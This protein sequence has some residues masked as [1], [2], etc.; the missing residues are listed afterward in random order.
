ML[1]VLLISLLLLYVPPVPETPSFALYWIPV[2]V[3]C[4]AGVNALACWAGS[5]TAVHLSNSGT[6][7]GALRAV[8]VFK[9]LNLGILGFV[10]LDVYALRWPL[11][12][13]EAFGR[14]PHVPLAAELLLLS[15]VLLMIGTVM[16]FQY[17][18]NR[19]QRPMSL[20]LGQYLLLRFRTELAILLVPWLLLVL[21]WDVAGALWRGSAHFGLVEGLLPIVLVGAIVA[22]AP[23]LLRLLWNTSPLPPGPVRERLEAFGR[24]Q[25]FR[26]RDIL[27]WHTHNYLPNAAVVGM[28]PLLRYVLLTDALL[29]NC[30]EEEIEGV[31][32]HEVGHIKHHHL[33]FYMLFVLAFVCFYANA[34][35]ILAGLGYVAP[36]GNVMLAELT[37]GHAIVMLVFAALYWIFGFGYLSR[38]F[39]QQADL[40]SMSSSSNPAAFVVALHKLAVL[41]GA[42]SAMRSWRHFSIS[43]RTEFLADVLE[44]PDLGR[45]AERRVR[46]VQLIIIALF[47]AAAL[48]LVLV[49]PGMVGL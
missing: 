41:S 3:L 26:C 23:L 37:H 5:R 22:F 36:L 29:A 16:A 4:L 49:A 35:D 27:L 42:P 28:I 10:V 24:A 43:R 46:L 11:L 25:G 1:P 31:F 14:P 45:R 38:R 19:T 20:R 32:A 33:G 9:L 44:N 7:R 18:F 2:G 15:P 48:R 12:V 39:E 34:V 40:F 6:A 8:R 47:L 30:T 17:W 13:E 21:V